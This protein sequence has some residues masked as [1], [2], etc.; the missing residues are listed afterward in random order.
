MT[1]ERK[2]E[3]DERTGRFLTGNIGGGRS[4]GSRNKLGEAFLEDMLHAWESRGPEAIQAV[5]NTKPEAF[6]KVVAMLMPKEM[7]VNVNNLEQMTDEQLLNRMRKLDEQIRP[8]LNALPA[9]GD[10]GRTGAPTAH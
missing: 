8:F 3:K 6:L 1:D 4:K 10:S 5:I 7:N 2:P 9:G